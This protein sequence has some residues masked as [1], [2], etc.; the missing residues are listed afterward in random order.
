MP[1]KVLAKFTSTFSKHRLISYH[2]R[3]IKCMG[4]KEWAHYT[5]DVNHACASRHK[6]TVVV[7]SKACGRAHCL[8]IKSLG[9]GKRLP[10]Q[11]LL[12]T[13]NNNASLISNKIFICA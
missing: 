2:F 8:C 3:H 4:P 12:L 9:W 6:C 5:Y 7:M 10:W 13:K 11:L 1:H